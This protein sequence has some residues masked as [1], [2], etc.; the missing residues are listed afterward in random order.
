MQDERFVMLGEMSPGDEGKI[1][2]VR[3]S[4]DVRKKLADMGLVKGARVRVVRYSPLGDPIE[5]RVRNYNLTLRKDEAKF[6]LVEVVG[7]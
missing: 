5:V 6:V 4:R 2:E 1:V 3:G 7:K